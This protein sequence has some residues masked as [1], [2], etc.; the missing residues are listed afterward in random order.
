MSTL[1]PEWW[2]KSHHNPWNR[3]HAKLRQGVSQQ[4]GLK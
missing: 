4:L 3:K 1:Y 2:R